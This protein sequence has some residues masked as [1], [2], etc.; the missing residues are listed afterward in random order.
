[1]TPVFALPVPRVVRAWT[2]RMVLS[3]DPASAPTTA[4]PD[5]FCMAR[6]ARGDT[7]ALRP[8]FDRWKLPLL[9]FFYRS[10]GSRADAEDLA[11][12]VFERVFRAAPRY[13]PEARFST[14]LFAIAR[15]EL[16]HELRRRK[17][18][19]VEPVAPADLED[20]PFSGDA[21]ADDVQTREVEAE[22]LASLQQLPERQRSALLL[23]AAGDLSH[24]AIAQSLGV[25]ENNLNVILHRARL[26][27]RTLFHP[28][29]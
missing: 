9:T 14:W 5:Q 10:V 27:L 2:W 3:G 25:S 26:A 12:Q 21:A 19:P 24:A 11:L 7:D 6:L 22:L 13:R 4:D 28:R 23:A 15:R 1:M 29:P 20:L 16:L 18:K 8:I 17:R